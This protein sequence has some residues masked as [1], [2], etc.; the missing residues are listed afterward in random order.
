MLGRTRRVGISR[1]RRKR[2]WR[3]WRWWRRRIHS[4]RRFTLY[5]RWIGIASRSHR[6][7]HGRISHRRTHHHGVAHVMRRGV[8]SP[9]RRRAPRA[10]MHYMRRRHVA[11]R[12]RL[13]RLSTCRHCRWFPRGTT[14]SLL[15]R[16]VRHSHRKVSSTLVLDLPPLVNERLGPSIIETV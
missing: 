1:G 2:T 15:P 8:G 12:R 5:V 11:A 4:M 10:R 6:H 16:F 14:S 7:S 3:W 13:G 9:W